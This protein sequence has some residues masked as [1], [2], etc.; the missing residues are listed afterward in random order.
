MKKFI[1]FSILTVMGPMA[2]AADGNAA[3]CYDMALAVPPALTQMGFQA[4]KILIPSEGTICTVEKNMVD[5]DVD[6]LIAT[7]QITITIKKNGRKV[8]EYE[9][10][11][12]S[13]EGAL[14][15]IHTLYAANV[16]D[17][18][19]FSGGSSHKIIHF[20]MRNDHIKRGEYAGRVEIGSQNISLIKR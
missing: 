1:L 12:R 6:G 16:A 8:A 4:E 9:M 18:Q 2:V 13:G 5:Q 20:A 17:L 3:E 14:G 15:T 10:A 7:G 19:D 11:A